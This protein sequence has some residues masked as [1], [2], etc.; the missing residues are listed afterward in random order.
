MPLISVQRRLICNN[1]DQMSLCLSGF[2]GFEG[3]G[4]LLAL[5][6]IDAEMNPLDQSVSC[7]SSPAIRYLL[8]C[9]SMLII[10]ALF[11]VTTILFVFGAFV[12]HRTQPI[13][14]HEINSASVK[15]SHGA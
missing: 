12:R 9:D 14:P 10:C 11:S 7:L 1:R 5:G 3:L 15:V 8:F 2:G 13:R 6:P 4:G